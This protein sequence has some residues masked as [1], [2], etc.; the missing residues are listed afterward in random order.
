MMMRIRGSGNIDIIYI[1]VK[2]GVSFL[3]GNL[4]IFIKIFK[5]CI[6][7]FGNFIVRNLFVKF[8]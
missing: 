2:I 7:R 5:V 6:K 4:V 8:Y 3:E 1:G